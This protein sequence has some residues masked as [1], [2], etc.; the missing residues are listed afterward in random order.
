MQVL[1]KDRQLSE[2]VASHD[3]A[4][5]QLQITADE[6]VAVAEAAAAE[7]VKEATAKQT[8][9]TAKLQEAEAAVAGRERLTGTM[10]G[11]HAG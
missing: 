4:M 5:R 8:E 11:S 9:W 10:Q 2:V 7:H 1:Q 3:S 6:R